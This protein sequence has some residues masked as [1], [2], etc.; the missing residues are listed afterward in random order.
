MIYDI[1]L[2]LLICMLFSVP[3]ILCKRNQKI[4][5]AMSNYE[6]DD[7]LDRSDEKI[8][9]GITSSLLDYV[10]DTPNSR[11]AFKFAT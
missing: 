11:I 8:E 9:Y 7:A 1:V 5:L 10:D 3:I 6:S 4:Q 2:I